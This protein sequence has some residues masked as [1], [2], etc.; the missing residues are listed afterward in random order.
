MTGLG[1][2][3]CGMKLSLILIKPALIIIEIN[4][5]YSMVLHIVR[6]DFCRKVLRKSR[7]GILKTCRKA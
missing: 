1:I 2:T 5:L 4:T 6:A 7:A 3:Y